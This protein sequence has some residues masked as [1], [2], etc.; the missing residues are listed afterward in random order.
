M[1]KAFLLE[2]FN[3]FIQHEVYEQLLPPK[4]IYEVKLNFHAATNYFNPSNMYHENRLNLN[5]LTHKL[6]HGGLT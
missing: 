4:S 1:N 3:N 2:A 6:F 5:N